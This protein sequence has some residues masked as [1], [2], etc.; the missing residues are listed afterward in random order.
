MHILFD[1]ETQIPVS[2]SK[3]LLEQALAHQLDLAHMCNGKARCSTC[4]VVVL[5][6]DLPPRNE[7]EQQLADRLE[8]PINV[9][10]SCQVRAD[11]P[12]TIRRVI[13][14]QVD[15]RLLKQSNQATERP[16]AV[17]FSDIRSF[18]SFSE[19]H[20]PYDIV[21]ILNRYFLAMGE[22]I[23][24]NNGRIDKY[25]GDGIM[26]LFGLETDTHP[27]VLAYKAALDMQRHLTS[28]N[29]YLFDAFGERF[30]MGIGIHYGEVVVGNLGHPNHSNFTAIGDAVNVAS[31]IESATK[32][33]SPL[34]VSEQAYEALGDLGWSAVELHVKGKSE[35]IR[36]Y[37]PAVKANSEH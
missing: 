37:G 35:P 7:A 26:A 27:A 9:R 13:R 1:H 15:H 19:R 22:A 30:E 36:A 29:E 24:A 11:R 23:L 10:I 28:F 32:G 5:D 33:V 16:L 18:T 25:M 34:L 6:G 3:S 17:L 2:P 8:L 14:D 31:R 20:L 21:H 12:M 4:R